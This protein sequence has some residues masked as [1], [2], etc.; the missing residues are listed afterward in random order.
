MD[1]GN[2]LGT[3]TDGSGDAGTVLHM[4]GHTGVIRI[5]TTTEKAGECTRDTGTVRITTVATGDTI[6]MIATTMT[7]DHDDLTNRFPR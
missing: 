6:I 2:R 1:I 5:M 3:I 7:T 4:T